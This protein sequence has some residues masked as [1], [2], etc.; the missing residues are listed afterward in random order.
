MMGNWRICILD[1]WHVH[2]TFRRFR[3]PFAVAK[4]SRP[5]TKGP[6]TAKLRFHLWRGTQKLTKLFRIQ[7]RDLRGDM[8]FLLFYSC[9]FPF[10]GN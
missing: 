10:L 1:T 7:E 9:S 3:G 5:A 4:C 6:K 8:L 2:I